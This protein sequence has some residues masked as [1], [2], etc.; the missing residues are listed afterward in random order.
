MLSLFRRLRKQA[1]RPAEHEFKHVIKEAEWAN[2]Q[3]S[4]TKSSV[5]ESIAAAGAD[6]ADIE[7]LRLGYVPLHARVRAENAR[8]REQQEKDRPITG[9]G[10]PLSSRGPEECRVDA[11][12]FFPADFSGLS[13]L[14]QSPQPAPLVEVPAT[15]IAATPST[16]IRGP[17]LDHTIAQRL[18]EE[19]LLRIVGEEHMRLFRAMGIAAA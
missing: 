19:H 3:E 15:R 14:V 11:G 8:I 17:I 6:A 1:R 16:T 9:F 18:R 13:A 7:E 10:R 4:A 12:H 5:A 2:M